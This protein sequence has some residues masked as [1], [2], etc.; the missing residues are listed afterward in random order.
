MARVHYDTR[1]AQHP[2]LKD[3]SRRELAMLSRHATPLHLD[4][5]KRLMTQGAF[6]TEFVMLE[7]GT[8]SV[9]V[10][11]E[12]VAK[13]GDGDFCGEMALLRGAYTRSADVVAETEMDVFVFDPRGFHQMMEEVPLAAE[14]ILETAEARRN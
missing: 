2:L 9:T 14:R 3:C 1:L 12:Q 4:K 11:G 13:L 10:D 8:A 7:S 5:G 6:G